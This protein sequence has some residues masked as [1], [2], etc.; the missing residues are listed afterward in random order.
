MGIFGKIRW[1]IIIFS[2]LIFFFLFT[3]LY[4]ILLLPIFTD[5]SIYIYWAKT[6]ATTHSHWLISL[7]DG[8]PPLLIWMIAI[9]LKILPSN[10]Y[11]LA[12]RLPSVIS[13]LLTLIAIFKLTNLLFNNKKASYIA[14]F[15]YIV[16][17]FSLFYDRMAL[18]DSLLCAMLIWSVYFSVK[19]ARTFAYKDAIVWGVYLGLAFLAKPPAGLFLIFTPLCFF[20]FANK[21]KIIKNKKRLV[22]LLL[23]PTG[24]SLTMDNLQ[25][26]SR[27]YTLMQIKNQQFQYAIP[28]VL[29][30]PLLHI[31]GNI[32]GLFGWLISYM[33]TPFFLICLISA[34]IIVFFKR[35]EGIL[36]LSLWFFSIMVFAFIGRQLFPRYILFILPYPIIPPAYLVSLLVRRSMIIVALINVMAIIILFPALTFDLF[37]LTNPPKAAFPETD[38]NQY[39]GDHP[40]GYGLTQIF[41]FL[42]KQAAIHK[43]TVVTQGTF[44]LYPYAFNLEFWDNKNVSIIGDWPLLNLNDKIIAAKKVGI[45]YLVF[46]EPTGVSPG[47]PLETILKAQKPSGKYPIFLTELVRIP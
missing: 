43:I 3:R 17:P 13:G 15:L 23:L 12:G 21:E 38:Y 5:E 1:E 14:M 44:G 47:M 2:F 10:L 7:S 9:F 22:T 32:N 35:K 36:L 6:I 8:K 31:P 24:I 18:F 30:N 39:I 26:L 46:K 45:V 4:N 16:M 33:T 40:S 19:T 29:A 41:S 25:R 27:A 11:L 42:H 20:L 28:E 34:V 37:I